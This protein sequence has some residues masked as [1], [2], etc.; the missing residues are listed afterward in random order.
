MEIRQFFR[1]SLSTMDTER[2]D[3]IFAIYWDLF[4]L[5]HSLI[6][7]WSLYLVKHWLGY[8]LKPKRMVFGAVLGA[9]LELGILVCIPFSHPVM[10]TLFSFL[11]VTYLILQ[12]V[13]LPKQL[14]I[15]GKIAAVY[16]L[17]SVLLGGMVELETRIIAESIQ[18]FVLPTSVSVCSIFLCHILKSIRIFG[19]ERIVPAKLQLCDGTEKTIWALWD[20]GNG[21]VDPMDQRPVCLLA[22]SVLENTGESFP[23]QTLRVIPYHSVGEERGL[24]KSYLFPKLTIFQENGVIEI[25][26]VRMALVPNTLSAEKQYQMILHPNLKTSRRK[27]H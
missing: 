15:S 11:P 22:E 6:N 14:L 8:F 19:T 4:L 5:Y 13:F 25:E 18:L 26:Q 10:G 7:F 16:C 3:I 27:K 24:L 21:L 9:V 23:S 2:G 1:M 20:T 12:I 17:S